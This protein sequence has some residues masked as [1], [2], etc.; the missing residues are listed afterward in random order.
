MTND[1]HELDHDIADAA[2]NVS[3]GLIIDQPWIG[4]ILRGEKT[5]EMRS[6]RTS[7]RGPI[8]LIE[9]GSGTVVGVASIVDSLGPLSL[10]DISENLPKHRVGREIH[11]KSDY[12]W[13]HAWVL[14]EVIPLSCPVKYRHK[15]GAVIW[16]DLDDAAREALQ[17]TFMGVVP[18]P[19]KA[20]SDSTPAS[21]QGSTDQKIPYARDGSSFCRE[22]CNRNGYFTVGDKGSEQRFANYSA[23][24]EYLKRMPT[25]KWRRPNP[26]G[27]WGIVSAVGWKDA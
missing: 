23:A 25:A 12:K 5:W 1:E 22:G 26:K 6:S 24:L 15:Q 8:A 19:S 13:N 11:T 17:K 18:R 21:V 9:K 3:R 2:T 7:I 14:D 20:V 27:N 16:V 10:H 4:K